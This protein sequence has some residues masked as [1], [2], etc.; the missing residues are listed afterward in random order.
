MLIVDA[1]LDL[2]YNALRGREVTRPA[3]EQLPRDTDGTPS[4]GLPDLVA[5]HVGLVCA[6]IFCEPAK[7]G[8]AGYTTAAQA[9]AQALAQLHWYQSQ[10]N[11]GT[12]RPVTNPEQLPASPASAG[13]S[14]SPI[15]AVILMEGADPFRSPDDVP[16]WFDAGLRIVGLAWK[17]TRMAGGT[18]EPG[19]LTAEGRALVKALDAHR[20]IHD[21]SH[22]AEQ[23]FW[24][25]LQLST[26]PV[27]AS[28]SNCRAIVPTDRQLSDEM[29][30]ALAQRGGVIGINFYDKFLLPPAQHKTRRAALAD[31]VA[32]VKH[33]CDL[34]GDAKHVGLGSDMDGGFGA[35]HI[36]AEIKTAADLPKIAHAL[37]AAG[38]NPQDV[39]GIL[40]GNWLRFFKENLPAA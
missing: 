13:G 7:G 17:S 15:P 35:E 4:V 31:L 19:P 3:A 32:H 33:M 28:H 9:R 36:P 34:L 1:H 8:H 20:I 24:Q 12:I 23:S 16:E 25:L 30:K 29:I 27:M 2:A 11:A 6:T 40:G 14:N 21:T 39:E 22:L 5:G 38:F 18:G 10:S 26:G 37:T